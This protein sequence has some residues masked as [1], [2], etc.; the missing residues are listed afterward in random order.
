MRT[1]GDSGAA[2]AWWCLTGA[3]LCLG[4][5]SLP[6]IGSFALLASFAL[7]GFLLWRFEFGWGM[8][9]LLTGAAVPVLYVAWLNR[10]GPGQVCHHDATSVSC[11]DQLNPW[12]LVA[13]AVG[14]VVAGFVVFARRDRG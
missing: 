5:L 10:D 9:G 7:S 13:V 6:S 2:F 3:G 14:L 4:V 12:P 1:K 11:S 8:A